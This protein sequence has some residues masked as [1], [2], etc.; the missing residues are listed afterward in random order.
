MIVLTRK[1]IMLLLTENC[2]LNC[3]YCYEHK[4]NSK[5]M[6]F[7][8]AKQIID[9]NLPNDAVE[10]PI[11]IEVFGG[12]VFANFSL[13]KEIYDYVQNNYSYLNIM[14]ETTTNG[15]LVHGEIQEW[16]RER[17]EQFFIALSLDGTR[18]MHDQ[19]RV[20]PDGKGSFDKIDIDFFAKTWPGCPAK[21][22]ISEKTLPHFFDGILYLESMGFKCDA[23]LAV[24]IDWDFEKNSPILIRE[25]EKLID[26]YI[27]NEEKPL[28]TI[29]NMD[30]RL[31]F[32]P[33]DNDY[34]FCGA[35]LDMTC[36]DTAGNEYPCQGF[37]P[38]SIGDKAMEYRGY[39]EKNFRFTESNMCRRC[40]WVRLCSNCYAAN[41]QSTDDIQ[42]VALNLCRFYKMCILASAKIQGIRL[43]K[44]E[45]LTHDDQLVL[46]AVSIIQ[47]EMKNETLQ[48]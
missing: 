28:C 48:D 6:S 20:F 43:L 10:E 16:L 12:E 23:T 14:Y 32:T 8:T 1:R 24:G 42:K 41:L 25:L 22:T 40:R 47:D 9:Q 30:L 26:Y 21:M 46:K 4:K 31:I 35:G 7:D 18:E 2:N 29:L 17:K 27:E 34:R 38:V 33:I 11:I 44:K 45:K 39:N 36:Y 5:R 37:A 3:L 19:N 15:T 13:L